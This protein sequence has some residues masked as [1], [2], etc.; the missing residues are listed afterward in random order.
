[1]A[2]E[3]DTSPTVISGARRRRHG[4]SL[5]TDSGVSINLPGRRHLLGNGPV[6]ERPSGG[7]AVTLEGLEKR[8][9]DEVAVD[10][11][12]LRIEPG[13]FFA[14]LGPSGCGKTTTLR[15]IGGFERPTSGR[16][17]IDDQDVSTIPPEKRP[18]NTVFQSYA[19][20]P[21]MSVADNVGFGLRFAKGVGKGERQ[22]TGGG[23]AGVGAP[24]PARPSTPEPALRRAAAA[25][26]A[27]PGAGAPPARAAA[28][29]AARRARR[30]V[31]QGAAGRAHLAPADRGDHL[32]VRDARPG[33]GPLDEPPPGGDAQRPD[34][35]DA[36][37]RARCTSRPRPRSWP[38]SWEWPTCST[39]SSTSRAPAPSLATRSTSTTARTG[40]PGRIVVRPERVQLAQRDRLGVR[41]QHG[42]GG[43]A[44][45]GLRRCAEPARHHAPDGGNLQVVMANDG[46]PVPAPGE[47]VTASLPADAIRVL[48]G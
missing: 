26:R 23:G 35:A 10:G 48:T 40:R 19:L 1:M 6:Q 38:S 9:D 46:R 41:G 33:G 29:R 16:V 12:D 20:F 28:R 43:R 13:E 31:A 24:E 42:V 27:G 17:L 44:G 21:H 22:A 11:I 8:F 32:R 4:P 3:P 30:Q 14:L 36:G 45:A 47:P 7:G 18:V 39:S 34:G 37:G 2:S 25:R 5:E 15:M